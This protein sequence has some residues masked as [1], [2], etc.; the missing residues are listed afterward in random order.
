[1]TSLDAP[2]IL[3]EEQATRA[4]RA[5][6][7]T[8]RTATGLNE[9]TA[10]E[11]LYE[12]IW[13]SQDNAPIGTEML[14]ALSKAGN[15][16]GVAHAGDAV[17]G[18]CVGFFAPPSDR[19]LHSHIAG[20]LPRSARRGVGY[21]LKLHQ[22]A[23]ALRRG[24]DVIEW[25]FDPLIARNAY[26]N[27][28]KL[29]GRP[30]EYLPNFYGGMRDRINTGDDTDRLLLQWHL[31]EPAVVAACSTHWQPLQV[32]RLDGPGCA[33]ALGRGTG[34]EPVPGVTE[35]PTLL[36]AVPPDVEQLRGS[37]PALATAWRF[38]VRDALGGLLARGARARAFT[39][40]GWYVLETGT[41]ETPNHRRG[42]TTP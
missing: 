34:G 7:I 13:R 37:D 36:V 30:A 11:E 41:P 8:V 40:D 38:A 26:F 12:Q 5:A 39:R 10:V 4:A 9:I 32:A 28:V 42:E 23:W 27:L 17:V 18:A 14:R 21:A 6:G 29:G 33:V 25:T 35:A 2:A 24:I 3:A 31:Q 15:Y 22:R 20:V 1:M 19:T 16:I